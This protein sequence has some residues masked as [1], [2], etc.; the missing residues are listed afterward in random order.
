MGLWKYL[1]AALLGGL[2][3]GTL[4]LGVGLL[5][6]EDLKANLQMPQEEAV[7]RAYY[8]ARDSVVKITA[9]EYDPSYPNRPS[10]VEAVGTGIVIRED[11]YLLTNY[12]VIKDAMGV[13]VTLS[14]G[15][16][17]G[18]VAGYDIGTDLAVVKVAASGLSPV[19]WGDS[20][21]LRPG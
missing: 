13:R 6:L 21:S 8:G 11:G 5:Y 18:E 19:S 12:H 4:V 10:P 7:A 1:G 20:A 17:E 9:L 16:V 3:A 15:E 14:S 2:V